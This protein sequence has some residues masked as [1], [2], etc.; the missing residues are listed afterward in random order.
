M[1]KV[2]RVGDNCT[3]HGCWVPRPIPSGASRTFVNN[4]PVVRTGDDHAPH[5]CPI[6]PETHSGVCGEGSPNVIIENAKAY[7]VGDPVS[8]GGV[9]AE[10]SPNVFVN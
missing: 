6:I 2:A 8:C 10:G 9:Q 7:R 4:K 5:T 3:G 1:P